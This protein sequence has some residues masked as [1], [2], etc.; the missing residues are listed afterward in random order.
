M[1]IDDV[2]VSVGP[3]DGD[4]ASGWSHG[5]AAI[6]SCLTA[7]G[8]A[9]ADEEAYSTVVHDDLRRHIKQVRPTAFTTA[10]HAERFA[11][12]RA[13]AG[14]MCVLHMSGMPACTYVTVCVGADCQPGV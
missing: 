13:C 10:S 14:I 6:S 12:L 7:L 11:S 5:L 3:A 9:S 8:L 2:M 4:A 1:S